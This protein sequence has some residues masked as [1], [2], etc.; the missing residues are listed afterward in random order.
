LVGKAEKG[1]EKINGVLRAGSRG[2]KEKVAK[3]GLG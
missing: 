2:E 3:E 1:E